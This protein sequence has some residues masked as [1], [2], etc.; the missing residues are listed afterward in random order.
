MVFNFRLWQG[1]FYIL[2]S[3]IGDF[4]LVE[5]EKLELFQSFEMFQSG[6][7]YFIFRE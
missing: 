3:S 5:L 2:N 4:G 7:G 6:V 1:I